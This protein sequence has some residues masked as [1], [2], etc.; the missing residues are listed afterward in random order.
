MKGDYVIQAGEDCSGDRFF[1]QQVLSG[2]C[3]RIDILAALGLE[4][5][6]EKDPYSQQM[7]KVYL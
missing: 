1:V 3:S 5:P 7:P 4:R 6:D 2:D